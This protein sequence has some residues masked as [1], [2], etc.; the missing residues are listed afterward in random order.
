MLLNE[1][2]DRDLEYDIALSKDATS[3]RPLVVGKPECLGDSSRLVLDLI[4]K[5]DP[6][7]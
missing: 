5:P 3:T 4:G 1:L 7:F 6:F 2:Q